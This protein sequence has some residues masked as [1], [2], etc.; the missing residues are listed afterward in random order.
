MNR[1]DIIYAVYERM[2]H[3][4]MPVFQ[5]RTEFSWDNMVLLNSE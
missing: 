3:K 5:T 1:E 4:F 2:P